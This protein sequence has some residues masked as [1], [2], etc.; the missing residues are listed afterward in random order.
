MVESIAS[1]LPPYQGSLM[2]RSGRLV[3]VKLVLR[4]VPIY[5]MTADNLPPWA[6]MDIDAICNKFFWE[7]RDESIRGKC[8]VA[9]EAVCRPSQLG[10]LGVSDLRLAGYALQ[11]RWLWLQ[12]TNQDRAWS[13]L[14]IK[15]DT[16][17]HMFFTASTLMVVGDGRSTLFWDDN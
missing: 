16:K 11:T 14:P 2:A 15:V 3:W 10:G 9:W 12:K 4:A 1:K 13:Q 7:G 17:V 5:A 8:M 6:C